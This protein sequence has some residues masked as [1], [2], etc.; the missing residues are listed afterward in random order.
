LQEFLRANEQSLLMLLKKL[1]WLYDKGFNTIISIQNTFFIACQKYE[2]VH[3]LQ[4][5]RKKSSQNLVPMLKNNKR[6]DG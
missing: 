2:M 3:L 1:I 6:G 5:T 4:G